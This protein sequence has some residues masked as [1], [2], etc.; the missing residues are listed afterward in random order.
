MNLIEIYKNDNNNL[1]R[2]L[3]CNQP[4]FVEEIVKVFN[5]AFPFFVCLSFQWTYAWI[6][7]FYKHNHKEIMK[8]QSIKI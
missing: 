7:F 2:R 4:L 1:N 5:C 6:G 3:A 8:P